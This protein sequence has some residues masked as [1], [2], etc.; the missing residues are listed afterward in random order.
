MTVGDHAYENMFMGCSLTAA[1]D[2]PAT[3]VGQEGYRGMFRDCKSL[4]VVPQVFAAT[5]LGPACCLEMFAGCTVIS[6]GKIPQATSMA[7]NCFERMYSGCSSL[8]KISASPS[9][10][11]CA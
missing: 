7:A 10:I 4:I 9:G 6:L 8:H 3:T 2:L 1:P 11:R 5:T